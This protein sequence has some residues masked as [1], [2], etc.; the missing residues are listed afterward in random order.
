MAQGQTATCMELGSG[1]VTA[2]VFALR[3]FARIQAEMRPG[4]MVMIW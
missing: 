3:H 4:D 1:G 2:H